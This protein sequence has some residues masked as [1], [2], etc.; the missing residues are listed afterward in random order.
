MAS[1]TVPATHAGEESRRTGEGDRRPRAGAGCR[2]PG[3]CGRVGLPSESRTPGGDGPSGAEVSHPSAVRPDGPDLA[4]APPGRTTRRGRR[5]GCRS[6]CPG[7]PSPGPFCIDGDHGSSWGARRA[8]QISISTSPTAAVT[9]IWTW[10]PGSPLDATVATVDDGSKAGRRSVDTPHPASGGVTGRR[11]RRRSRTVRVPSL[12]TTPRPPER[13]ALDLGQ[14][15]GIDRVNRLTC[16]ACAVAVV[17]ARSISDSTALDHRA[18]PAR[19]GSRSRQSGH[20]S[21]RRPAFSPPSR[22]APAPGGRAR[23]EVRGCVGP[24]HRGSSVNSDSLSVG[25]WCAPPTT[26]SRVASGAV[27]QSAPE[28]R[29]RSM[30]ITGVIRCRR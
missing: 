12:G 18:G 22:G 24:W 9:P 2:S 4:C 6:R 19:P 25:A 3:G 21:S 17:R 13:G 15:V 29:G 5:C 30:P 20:R 7:T 23:P 8:G 16:S 28:S 1:M 14:A 27:S 26:S 10:A 11:P